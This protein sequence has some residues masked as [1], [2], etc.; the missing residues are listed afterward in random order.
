MISLHEYLQDCNL[1]EH[2]IDSAPQFIFLIGLP[3]A[4]KS[5]FI[6]KYLAKYFP[7]ITTTRHLNKKVKPG[8]ELNYKSSARLLDKDVQLHRQQKLEAEAFS[9]K[10]FNVDNQEEF[11]RI[12]QEELDRINNSKGQQMT[13]QTFKLSVDW[14]WVEQ[15]KQNKASFGKFH[16]DYLKEFFKSD[17]AIDFASRPTD[18]KT[19]F[20]NNFMTKL[21]PKDYEGLETFNNN[22]LVWA[23]CG[24]EIDKIRH[25]IET[26]GDDYV[27]SIVYL[28]MP[29]DTAVE[30]DE[31]RRK[32]E[33]RGVGRT[34][35]EKK[36][37][38]LDKVWKYLSRG[39]FKNEGIYKLLHFKFVPDGGWGHYELEKEYINKDMIKDYEI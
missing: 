39:G 31:S 29:V 35:I 20:N 14:N 21:N 11:E 12:K 22:D 3:A 19:D 5:T 7:N 24:D 32:K 16:S 23:T 8:K 36:A 34:I 38:G 33:G 4:G 6:N 28:D 13:K 15:Y 26:A 30:K 10:I 18:A 27:P 37:E 25:A 1:N 9:K 2:L 17:W